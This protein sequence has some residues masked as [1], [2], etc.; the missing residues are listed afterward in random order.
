ML[1][2]DNKGRKLYVTRDGML[3]V[4]HA[5]GM[6]NGIV[7]DELRRNTAGDGWTCYVSVWRKDWD[8]PCKMGAQ[9]KDSEPQA[10]Q[11]HGPEMALARAE[12]RALKRAFRIRSDFYP[13]RPSVVEDFDTDIEPPALVATAGEGAAR[14]V[15]ET[16]TRAASP[17]EWVSPT[18]E[19]DANIR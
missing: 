18:R 5:S 10:R 13:E 14:E 9:C 4:A 15:S 2:S 1:I 6:L 16:T 12:R 7:V 8:Y 11:G 3:A 19:Q 17:D